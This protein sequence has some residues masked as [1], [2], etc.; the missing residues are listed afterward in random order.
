M[1]LLNIFK[2]FVFQKSYKKIE[3]LCMGNSKIIINISDLPEGCQSL[4]V[5]FL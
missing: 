1:V 5:G 3:K 4:T 2:M